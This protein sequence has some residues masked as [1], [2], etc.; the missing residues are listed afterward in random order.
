MVL[1]IHPRSFMSTTP[2]HPP[3][4][5]HPSASAPIQ[6]VYILAMSPQSET[7]AIPKGSTVLVTG[8]NGYLASHVVDQFLQRGFNV[9][10]TVRNVAKDSWLTDLFAQ[11]YG[12]GRFELREV[13]DLAAEGTFNQ[14]IKGMRTRSRIPL[15]G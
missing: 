1:D 6:S 8:A 9:R 10:G 13:P 5:A 2:R 14:V 3:S 11:K 15:K 4:P 7:W 12:T